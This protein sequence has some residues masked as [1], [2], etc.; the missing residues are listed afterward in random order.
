MKYIYIILKLWTK[1]S[2]L[3]KVGLIFRVASLEHVHSIRRAV[4]QTVA[5]VFVQHT[6][7]VHWIQ[8]EK[9]LGA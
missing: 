5:I 8:P 9:Q 6:V 7:Q 1:K 3:C 4:T 2:V